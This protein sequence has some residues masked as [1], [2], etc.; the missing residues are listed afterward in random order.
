ME[1]TEYQLT[2]VEDDGCCPRV[3]AQTVTRGT[4]EG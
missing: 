1:R 3:K 2:L 4:S